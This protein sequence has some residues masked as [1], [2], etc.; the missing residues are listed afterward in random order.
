[1]TVE[2]VNVAQSVQWK[3][4]QDPLVLSEKRGS[5]HP[6]IICFIRSDAIKHKSVSQLGTT[7]ARWGGRRGWDTWGFSEVEIINP[8]IHETRSTGRLMSH[9]GHNGSRCV[10]IFVPQRRQSEALLELLVACWCYIAYVGTYTTKPRVLCSVREI[11]EGY[12]VSIVVT[13]LVKQKLKFKSQDP[14]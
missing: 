11:I 1:M 4:A 6:K 2:T 7:C 12:C 14:K 5:G 3:A 10:I 9:C 8:F 13:F